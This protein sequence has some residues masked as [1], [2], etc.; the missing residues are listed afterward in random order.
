[1]FEKIKPLGDRV[2]VKRIET[3]N[4]TASGIYIPDVAQGKGQMGAVVAVGTG[5]KDVSGNSIPMEI[6]L[7]DVVFFGQYAGI[8]AGDDHLII[9]EDE[10]LGVIQK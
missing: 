8:D 10:L 7:N 3:K 9:K 5:K 4:Q 2:L 6:K 1:M